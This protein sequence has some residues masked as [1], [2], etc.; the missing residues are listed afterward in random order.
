MIFELLKDLHAKKLYFTSVERV[1][2][3]IEKNGG[4]LSVNDISEHLSL[5]QSDVSIAITRLLG[6]QFIRLDRKERKRRFY[7]VDPMIHIKE[8]ALRQFLEPIKE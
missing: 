7:K 2:L 3:C 4:M 5:A 1:F 8:A 6:M